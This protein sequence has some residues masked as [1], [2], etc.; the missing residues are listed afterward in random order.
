MELFST[1]P[2][3]ARIVR[4]TLGTGLEP[5]PEISDLSIDGIS[6]QVHNKILTPNSTQQM[7]FNS[8]HVI[9]PISTQQKGDTQVM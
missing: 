2:Q 4:L 5:S 9:T 8:S 7:G 3:L 6:Q 1:K